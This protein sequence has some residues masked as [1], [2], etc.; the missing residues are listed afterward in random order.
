MNGAAPPKKRDPK[1]NDAFFTEI[2]IT[3]KGGWVQVEN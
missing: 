2:I 1:P 3:P